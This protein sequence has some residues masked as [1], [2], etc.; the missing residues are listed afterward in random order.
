MTMPACQ[1]LAGM[2]AL[3]KIYLDLVY[4]SLVP[5]PQASLAWTAVW[6]YRSVIMFAMKQVNQHTSSLAP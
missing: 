1:I 2:E 5:V 4:A 6:T 3:V